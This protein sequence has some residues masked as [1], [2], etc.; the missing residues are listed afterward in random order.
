MIIKIY[1][2]YFFNFL[3]SC[4]RE[5][6]WWIPSPTKE[7]RRKRMAKRRERSGTVNWS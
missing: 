2:L 4:V 6:P 7:E 1:V 5:R 3:V